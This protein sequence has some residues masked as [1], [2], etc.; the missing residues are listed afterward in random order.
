MRV[1]HDAQY[2]DIRD[3]KKKK[4]AEL[5]CGRTKRNKNLNSENQRVFRGEKVSKGRVAHCLNKYPVEGGDL[6]SYNGEIYR[7]SGMRKNGTVTLMIGGKDKSIPMQEIKV[8]QRNRGT[9]IT[10]QPSRACLSPVNV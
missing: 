10:M 4:A 9:Y 7:A 8:L 3:G 2:I 5:N 1:V 6:V